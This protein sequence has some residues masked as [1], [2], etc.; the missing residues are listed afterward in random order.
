MTLTSCSTHQ[1]IVWYVK[2]IDKLER[3][4]QHA[5]QSFISWKQ[6][7]DAKSRL[8]AAKAMAEAVRK[9]MMWD[10]REIESDSAQKQAF[11]A[12]LRQKSRQQGQV[13]PCRRPPGGVK[14][15]CSADVQADS[16][17]KLQ[18]DAEGTKRLYQDLGMDSASEQILVD[19]IKRGVVVGTHR[20]PL[21]AQLYRKYQTEWDWDAR[22]LGKA[23]RRTFLFG[24]VEENCAGGIVLEKFLRFNDPNL[25]AV[26]S[27][28]SAAARGGVGL[29]Q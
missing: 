22:A 29:E 12:W 4:E 16:K 1:H 25:P 18:H 14:A 8:Q 17:N 15:Q 19:A 11:A 2:D 21:L 28:I 6:Q 20:V 3:K 23:D 27:K 5:H 7:Y 9:Q 24:E 13:L 26:K 10:Q